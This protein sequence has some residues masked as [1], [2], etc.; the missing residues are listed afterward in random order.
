MRNARPNNL[1]RIN[2][3]L[4]AIHDQFLYLTDSPAKMASG[5]RLLLFQKTIS[6]HFELCLMVVPITAIA[7]N[8]STEQTPYATISQ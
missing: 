6:V 7:P 2:N 4:Q 1:Q 3:A 8:T 5:K